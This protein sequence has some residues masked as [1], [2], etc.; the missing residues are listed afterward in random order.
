MKKCIKCEEEKSVDQYIV[1]SDTGKRMGICNDCRN[2]RNREQYMEKMGGS[3]K[4]E[5]RASVRESDPKV[6]IKCN[7]S[8]PLDDF[9]W[10]NREKGQHRNFCRDCQNVWARNHNQTPDAKDVRG[11]WNEDNA[12]KIQE[13]K[14]LYK[15][16]DESDPSRIKKRSAYSRMWRLKKFFN[17]TPEQYDKMLELQDGKC[18]IC[19]TD[20]PG[21][22][23]KNFMV[24]HCHTTG[25]VRGLLCFSCNV[26]IGHMNDDANLFDETAKYLRKH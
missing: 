9:N 24:D 21:N 8:K 19:K 14:D 10:H 22:K 5:Q 20:S 4:R 15:E 3:T 17:L 13:Y 25:K 16:L 2:K 12:E 26:S 1:R 11:K 18:M 23:R 7:Q 6:C